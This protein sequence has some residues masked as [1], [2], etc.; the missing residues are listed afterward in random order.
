MFDATIILSLFARRFAR[1]AATGSG[2]RPLGRPAPLAFAGNHGGSRRHPTV[3]A[4]S[5]DR[6]ISSQHSLSLELQCYP[7]SAQRKPN[8]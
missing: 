1:L 7:K 3:V 4:L 8:R 2:R 5:A 6:P